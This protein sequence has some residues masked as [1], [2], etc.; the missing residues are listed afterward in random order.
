MEISMA[1]HIAIL[2]N[3][4]SFF[5]RKQRSFFHPNGNTYRHSKKTLKV[6]FS[7]IREFLRRS[8]SNPG[9]VFILNNSEEHF[10]K[11][12]GTLKI[13]PT[14]MVIFSPRIFPVLATFCGHEHTCC[15][16]IQQGFAK[17]TCVT[18]STMVECFALI[19]VIVVVVLL[20][21]KVLQ[22][23]PV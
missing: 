12:E 5:S 1:A 13:I 17:F 15:S 22:N 20:S 10:L 7:K 14:K 23:L 18:P 3:S 21:N 4:R 2:K 11:T 8:S 19:V 6:F 16:F 9:K